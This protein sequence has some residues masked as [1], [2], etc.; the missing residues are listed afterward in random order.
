MPNKAGGLCGRSSE[1]LSQL[2]KQYD[3]DTSFSKGFKL[4]IA[5]QTTVSKTFQYAS[6]DTSKRKLVANRQRTYDHS[7]FC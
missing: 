6:F 2:V 1:I 7:L 3:Q 4:H 5:F